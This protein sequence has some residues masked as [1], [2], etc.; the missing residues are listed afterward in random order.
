MCLCADKEQ[1]LHLKLLGIYCVMN[2]RPLTLSLCCACSL[3]II[4]IMNC[5]QL[6]QGHGEFDK[7]SI[8]KSSVSESAHLLV[9]LFCTLSSWTPFFSLWIFGWEEC[10]SLLGTSGSALQGKKTNRLI[11]M[12]QLNYKSCSAFLCLSQD[13]A[14]EYTRHFT[15]C[16]C[17]DIVFIRSGPLAVEAAMVRT[18]ALQRANL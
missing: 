1:E 11:H 6:G 14:P 4:L 8:M 17:A 5:S 13:G 3:P 10:T 12:N 18:L 15:R 2:E 9:C 7:M 16:A